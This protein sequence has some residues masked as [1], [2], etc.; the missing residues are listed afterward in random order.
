MRLDSK[1]NSS[2]HMFFLSQTALFISFIFLSFEHLHHLVT[3]GWKS[4]KKGFEKI[5]HEL[6]EGFQDGL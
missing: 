1:C 6:L 2:K 5:N 3:T 4:R